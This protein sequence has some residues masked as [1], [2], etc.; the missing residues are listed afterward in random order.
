MWSMSNIFFG[1]G[2]KRNEASGNFP[3]TPRFL[4]SS[5]DHNHYSPTFAKLSLDHAQSKLGII[6]SYSL[7]CRGPADE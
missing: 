6:V 5:P 3:P 4:L 1:F 7:T 2:A